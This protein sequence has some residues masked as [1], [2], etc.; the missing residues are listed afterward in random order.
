[1]IPHLFVY[2]TLMSHTATE[3]ARQLMAEAQSLGP[4]TIVGRLYRISWYPGLVEGAGTVHGEVFQ[5]RDP[6]RSL[7]WLDAYEGITPASLHAPAAQ[8]PASTTRS[9][10]PDEYER[11][12]RE[13]TLASGTPLQAWVYVY[14][15]DVSG[16]FPV[17]EG[18]WTDN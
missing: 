15:N 3:K 18:R 5:L 14:R 7:A 11:V 2:G 10:P 17:A 4:A 16:C 13:V 1:M 8:E 12:L 9:A 6:A